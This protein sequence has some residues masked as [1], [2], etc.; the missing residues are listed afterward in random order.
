MALTEKLRKENIDVACLQETH[1]KD[2]QRFTMRGYQVFRHDREGRAKWG[3]AILVKNT[4]PAHEFT[5]STNNQAEIHG[6]SIIMNEKHYKIFNIIYCPPDRDLSLDLMHPQ[7]SRC[8]ILGDF[9]SHSE[10]WGYE[11]RS[12]PKRRGSRRLAG[13]QWPCSPERS[14]WPTNLLFKTMAQQYYTRSGFRYQWPLK[15][16]IQNCTEPAWRERPQARQDQPRPTVQNTEKQH[17]PQMELQEGQLG[18]FLKISWSI[19]AED[20]Q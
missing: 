14:W 1:L 11:W 10:A 18:M 20:Q 3:V 19:H 8:I 5:V 6:V 2:N 13:W 4:I 12:R 17:I 7:E 9:N 16:S 15:D